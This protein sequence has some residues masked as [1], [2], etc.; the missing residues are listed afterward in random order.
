MR[1]LRTSAYPGSADHAA[2]RVTLR[3]LASGLSSPRPKPRR[4]ATQGEG[5]IFAREVLPLYGKLTVVAPGRP[6]R[7]ARPPP[8]LVG[9]SMPQFRR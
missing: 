5:A 3:Q 1:H 6:A 7:A 4:A 2:G 8:V 9:T